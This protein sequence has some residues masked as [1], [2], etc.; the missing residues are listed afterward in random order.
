VDDEVGYVEVLAKR[1]AKRGLEVTRAFNGTE[2]IRSLRFNHF[3]VAVVDLKMEDVDGVEVL[4]IFKRMDPEM[5]VI[6][7]TGH[8][9]EQAARDAMR[10][11]A[12]DYLTKPCELADLLHK[13]HEAFKKKQSPLPAANGLG[14]RQDAH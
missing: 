12:F 2:A 11:G 7:L 5:E 9:S 10:L 14:E 3:D 8:G 13:I 6:M 4:R 1:L